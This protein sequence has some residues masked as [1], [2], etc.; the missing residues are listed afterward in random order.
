MDNIFET[1]G[2]QSDGTWVHGMYL[3]P[4]PYPA[5]LRKSESWYKLEDVVEVDESTLSTNTGFK[6]DDDNPIFTGDFLS[7]KLKSDDKLRIF[8][9]VRWS[10]YG[11]Y[12]IDTSFGLYDGMEPR[13]MIGR[14]LSLVA[15]QG[16]TLH[17]VGN[18]WDNKDMIPEAFRVDDEDKT[19]LCYKFVH[20]P[21][22]VPFPKAESAG[23]SANIK[24][25]QGNNKTY[26][27]VGS[28]IPFF[29]KHE[30]VPYEGMVYAVAS[31]EG[32]YKCRLRDED[33]TALPCSVIAREDNTGIIFVEKNV[34]P[35]LG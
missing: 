13:D 11:Y 23:A 5:I 14:T 25:C 16:H 24:Q 26:V 18:K 22:R 35:K 27:P 8:G 29:F 19:K 17:V 20:K 7:I 31:N 21:I 9:L 34:C 33:C 32:C 15:Y 10:R 28:G 30:K 4:V 1:R 2:K 6:D 3:G 12:F